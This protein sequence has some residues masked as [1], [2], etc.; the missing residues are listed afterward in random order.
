MTFQEAKSHGL[1]LEA[2]LDFA[3]KRLKSF[4]SYGKT[5]MGLTPDHV[6]AMPEWQQ[7]KKEFDLAL[8]QLRNF[9]GWYV[10]AFKK[11][12]AAE[13]KEKYKQA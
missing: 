9:N 11:E 1:Q 13:R 2:L 7:A 4:D 10:K 5:E 8:A 12:I 3:S 6:K